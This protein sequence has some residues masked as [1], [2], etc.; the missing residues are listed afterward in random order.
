MQKKSDCSEVHV[1]DIHFL[2]VLFGFFGRVAFFAVGL[3]VLY[4][5]LGEVG[6]GF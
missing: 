3:C 5:V 1:F 4:G 6:V 2:N